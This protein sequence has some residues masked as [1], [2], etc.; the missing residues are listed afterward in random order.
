MKKLYNRLMGRIDDMADSPNKHISRFARRVKDNEESVIETSSG[1]YYDAD[2]KYEE[3]TSH[4]TDE[5]PI[6]S[7]ADEIDDLSYI[8]SIK[9][10]MCGPWNQYDILLAASRYGWDYMVESADYLD[11]VDIDNI[12]TISVSTMI[13]T[14][15]TEYIDEYRASGESIS[16]MESLKNEGS[17][18][19][20][21]GMSKC[22]GGPVK[23][24]WINQTNIL[25]VFTTFDD[26]EKVNRYI[27]TVIRRTF[28][29]PDEMKK[30]KAVEE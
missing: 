7:Y 6:D 17:A 15:E 5:D 8:R 23:I 26:E 2:D 20:I 22:I 19:G 4:K 12:G 18:L 10:L 29:T 11:N 21:G 9:H 3:K 14:D 28:G 16:S 30:A 13:G 24:V 27:E 1:E 25:R